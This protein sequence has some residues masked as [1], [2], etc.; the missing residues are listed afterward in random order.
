[1]TIQ[2]IRGQNSTLFRVIEVR[3]SP[4]GCFCN[5]KKFFA[6]CL[7]AGHSCQPLADIRQAVFGNTRRGER[8]LQYDLLARE[9]YLK[10]SGLIA[11]TKHPSPAF[12]SPSPEAQSVVGTAF[13]TY[14]CESF[15]HLYS[16]TLTF[17]KPHEQ[18]GCQSRTSK[19][20]IRMPDVL[21]HLGYCQRCIPG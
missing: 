20:P 12:L 8:H 11:H 17:E 21:F 9:A 7:S 4:Q 2:K 6:V 15:L 13:Y 1:M 14:G 10:V 19:L 3:L 5:L 16:L 18:F